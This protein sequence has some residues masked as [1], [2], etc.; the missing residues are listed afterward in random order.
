MVFRHVE[1]EFRRDGFRRAQAAAPRLAVHELARQQPCAVA[2]HDGLVLHIP[3][4]K[5]PRGRPCRVRV[6]RVNGLH[7]PHA[8]APVPHAVE[9]RV[10]EPHLAVGIGPQ[11]GIEDAQRPRRVYRE[12]RRRPRVAAIAAG[13][14]HHAVLVTFGGVPRV[15]RHPQPPLRRDG[16]RR[17]R[18]KTAPLV[19]QPL[20]HGPQHGKR[21]HR[22]NRDSLLLRTLWPCEYR[23]RSQS[24]GNT[25]QKSTAHDLRHCFHS[26]SHHVASFRFSFKGTV[27]PSRKRRYD[28]T[29]RRW[30]QGWRASMSCR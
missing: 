15:P 13:H 3:M 16:Q 14:N 17:R 24:Y 30:I 7:R 9:L 25:D 6:L 4:A 29:S 8:R 18:L 2:R 28:N 12:E 27:P 21:L 23:R 10:E 26:S 11:A 22:V 20:R 19:P 1:D 5:P